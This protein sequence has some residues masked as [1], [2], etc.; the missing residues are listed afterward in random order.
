MLIN[1]QQLKQLSIEELKQLS[2]KPIVPKKPPPPSNNNN[3]NN[4]IQ[5]LSKKQFKYCDN[6]WPTNNLNY[7]DVFSKIKTINCIR[8]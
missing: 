1:E 2:K 7:F 5:Q 4:I 3:N 8:S 6:F